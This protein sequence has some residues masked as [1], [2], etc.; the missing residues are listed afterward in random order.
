M[1]R[2]SC[3]AATGI[4]KSSAVVAKLSPNGAKAANCCTFPREESA[5]QVAPA[6]ATFEP[7]TE[8]VNLLAEIRMERFQTALKQHQPEGVVIDSIQTMFRPNH[9]RPRLRI[10]GTR[11]RRPTDAHGETN[12]HRHDTGSDTLPKMARLLSRAYWNNGRYRAVFRGATN[13]PT[14]A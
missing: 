5:Q 7:P 11:M 2:S 13:I 12:G 3:S 1:A 10:A 8:G 4:G 6:R 9:L 14:T